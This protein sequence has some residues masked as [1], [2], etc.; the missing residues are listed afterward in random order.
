MHR[1]LLAGVSWSWFVLELGKPG[2]EI[3]AERS[4][5]APLPPGASLLVLYFDCKQAMP[6]GFEHIA[7]SCSA[8]M[9]DCLRVPV[10]DAKER[11]SW[12]MSEAERQEHLERRL[13]PDRSRGGR[14][15]DEDDD[16]EDCEAFRRF[17]EEELQ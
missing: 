7:Y 16:S 13:D 15:C 2:Y 10:A 17:V 11:A 14:E 4:D 1:S 3:L 9:G 8:F 12:G 5:A 6:S